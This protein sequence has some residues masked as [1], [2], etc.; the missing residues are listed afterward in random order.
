MNSIPDALDVA[1]F[2]AV[3]IGGRRADS[4]LE[5]PFGYALI[6]DA[7]EFFH[8]VRYD[9]VKGPQCLGKWAAYHGAKWNHDNATAPIHKPMIVPAGNS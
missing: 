3:R 6:A 5:M 4:L 2:H 1:V 9:G 8:W 7:D